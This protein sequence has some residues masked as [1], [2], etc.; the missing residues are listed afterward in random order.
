MDLGVTSIGWALVNEAE[1]GDETS[2]I[3]K[4]GVRVNP[5]TVDEADNFTKGKTITTNADRTLK[6][7]ARRNL[8]RYK[9][10]R[11]VLIKRLLDANIIEDT[12]CLAEQGNRTTF[13]TYR[14]RAKAVNEEISLE[15]FAR[16]LLMINKKRG[17]KS[18]R[19]TKGGDEGQLVDGMDVANELY[20]SNLT[21]AQYSL[22]LLQRRKKVLPEYYQSDLVDEFERVWARQQTFYPNLLTGKC[23]EAI[24]GKHKKGTCDYF[25]AVYQIS[26][27]EVKPKERLLQSL[28]LRVDAL[29]KRL[30]EDEL[31]YVLAELNNL[32][33]NA[34]NYLGMISDRS[35]ELHMNHLTVGQYLMRMIESS[36][37]ASLKNKVFYRRDYLD[38]FE[39]VW[40]TQ[41]K[42]H[43]E[44]T[45]DLKK[46]I[47]SM[48]IFYQRPL[49]SQKDKVAVCELESR[50]VEI[51]ENGKKRTITIGSKVCPKSSPL[52]QEY[53]IW[54]R[55]NDLRVIEK[56]TNECFYVDLVDK[57]RIADELGVKG[58]LSKTDVL[59]IL[60]LKPR[61]YELN[62]PALEGNATQAA[63]Y[64]A[65]IKILEMSGHEVGGLDKQPAAV[66]KSTVRQVFEALGFNTEPLDLDLNTTKMPWSRMP[67]Y[68]LWHLLYSYEG[69]NSDLGDRSLVKKLKEMFRF[70]S[71][72]YAKV[73]AAVTFPEDYASISAKAISKIL[74]YMMEG[75]DY[76]TACEYAGYNHSKQ[77]LTKE[78][79]EQKVL[80]DTLP[81]L[82]RNFLRNPVVEKILNQ[83]INVINA[84]TTTYGKPDEIRIEMAREL[85]K[86]AMEREDMTKTLA[87]SAKRNESIVKIL[88]EE[89]MIERPSRN[90]ILRYR[91]YK[92]LESNGYKTLY[93]NTYISQ[94]KLFS[95]EFDIEHIIPQARMFDDSFSNKTLEARQINIDKSDATAMDFVENRY[96]E[97]GAEEYR[98]RVDDLLAGKV[99]SKAKYNKLLMRGE[100]IP[101]D[102]LNRDL[103]DTQ[104]IARKAREILL[105]YVRTVVSTT[106][107]IT[108]RLREDWQLTDV[109]RELNWDKYETVG[110][111]ESYVDKNGN[112]VRRIKG[113]TK[114]NDH[115]HHAMDA[116]AI[117]FTKQSI[118]Q[119]LNNLN[120]RS[121]KAGSI[122]AIEKK[123][124]CRH[125]G[126]MMFVAPMPDFRREAK[127]A[128]ENILISIKSKSK[129]VTRNVNKSKGKKG[130]VNKKVQLTPRGQLHNETVY[131]C[132][133]RYRIQYEKVNAAFTEEKI[134]TVANKQEREALSGRLKEFGGDPKKAFTGRNT[135]EKNP[136]WLDENHTRAVGTK[137]KTVIKVPFYT[138]RKQITKDL[139]I[140]QVVDANI[141][142]LLNERLQEYGGDSAKAFSNLDENPIWLNKEKGISIKRVTIDAGLSQP[143]PLRTKKDVHGECLLN[144]DGNAVPVDYVQT[145]NNHHVAIFVDSQGKLQEHIV[146]FYEAT[147]RAIQ[148]YPVID[149][150][151]NSE[152]GWKFLFTM[153]R[154]EY[155]V[156]PA[157]DFEPAAV[158]LMDPS[159]AALISPH[160]FRVQKLATK[161]YTFRH[162]LETNVENNKDLKD[163]TW[164]R[165]TAIDKLSGIVKVRVNHIGQI[166][167]V[168]EY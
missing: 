34:G 83:M 74:P 158:D 28:H 13:Q 76:S 89:F 126:H 23:K 78:Q 1:E 19:K 122:Y 64:S 26:P 93:S 90:D 114:R 48:I 102:F 65:Y 72:D 4:L 24:S 157:E 116:L 79:I 18:N 121:D 101:Q 6:R 123:E 56:R 40:A 96:G 159:N 69:D 32:I 81:V 105:S 168:G 7:S 21:P 98:D 47:G 31:V 60:E 25:Y 148:G 111:T 147:S 62:F 22:N 133:L 166:V 135:L 86:S 85:K 151:Y 9:L 95:R 103:N 115:R 5:L 87:E 163:K 140:N 44:L 149:R 104:Y 130:T 42:Y 53:R 55:L 150:D 131:G 66:I 139:R 137:V 12:R 57:Q 88:K 106:G 51:N 156:F 112:T 75:N 36:P 84:I 136:L 142:R 92:E 67:M 153:K 161:D 58:K 107:S 167:A 155:F 132:N 33:Y 11:D 35:K 49:K 110:L 54:Q 50:Q 154:N 15:E 108:D 73:L 99:I 52:F 14:L 61:D 17:Y 39:T 80:V 43:P 165:I 46:E 134:L 59:K 94:E 162:H 3:I 38:E 82:P 119:Y 16:V 160:L 124:L 146:S 118:I 2:S 100:D 71:D 63:L 125:N 117:A 152:E 141:R 145:S 109:M 113:W 164:I 70:S 10:R 41:A 29:S 97:R 37:N 30:A 129:V 27:I 8:Q 20:A 77:S 68:Q 138:I 127:K 45:A 143:E 91:L 120:A 128:L 144:S